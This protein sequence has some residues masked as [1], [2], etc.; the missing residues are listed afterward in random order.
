MTQLA[1][2]VPV[3]GGWISFFFNEAGSVTG[4]FSFTSPVPVVLSVTDA[5]CVGDQFQILHGAR[6]ESATSTPAIPPD[7][8]SP[9]RAEEPDPAFSQGVFSAGMLL[10]PAGTHE[11]SIRV[12]S[13]PFEFGSG[14]LRVDACTLFL[15]GPGTLTGTRADDTLCGSAGG[16]LISGAAGNDRIAS[17]NGDDLVQGSG[18]ADAVAGG[19]GSDVLAGQNG[20]DRVFGDG[21]RDLIAGGSGVDGLNGGRA[22][23]ILAADAGPTNVVVGDEGAD[24]LAGGVGNDLL[25]GG[26]GADLLR[27]AHGFDTCDGGP[28]SDTPITCESLQGIP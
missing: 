10:L 12:T 1:E 6:V 9:F 26:S 21:G 3:D 24:V 4:P 18:G 11:I 17:G 15:T 14:F 28:G 8:E 19:Q 7:C 20:Q 27:G 23:D 5:F 13:S 16:D 22:D 25:S 2:P